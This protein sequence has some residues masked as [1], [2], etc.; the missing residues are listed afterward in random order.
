MQLASQLR[1]PVLQSS[2]FEYRL[3][4]ELVQAFFYRRREPWER[5]CNGMMG[6]Q[7]EMVGKSKVCMGI[8]C[9]AGV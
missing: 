6:N 4:C 5:D 9:V 2:G 1:A 8:A 3:D 7:D